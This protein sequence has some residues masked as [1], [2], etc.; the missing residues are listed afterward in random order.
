[1]KASEYLKAWKKAKPLLLTKTGISE[2]LRTLAEDPD[3]NALKTYDKVAKELKAKASAPKI[4][5]EKKAVACLLLIVQ[6]IEHF[7]ANTKAQRVQAVEAMKKIDAACKT[8]YPVVQKGDIKLASFQ[9]LFTACNQEAKKIEIITTRG[10]DKVVVPL[11]IQRAYREAYDKMTAKAERMLALL[12][13][14]MTG[15]PTMNIKTE[16]PIAYKK[17]GEQMTAMH[18][19]LERQKALN[20]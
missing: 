16:Y 9:T 4:K 5:D 10:M 12:K 13:D 1:M 14:N 7:L 3:H 20:S 17:F 15:K 19:L 18:A 8:F 11:E 6:D 2:S